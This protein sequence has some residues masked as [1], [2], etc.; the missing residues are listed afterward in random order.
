MAAHRD[1]L[2]NGAGKN[3]HI[4]QLRASLKPCKSQR[5][6]WHTGQFSGRANCRPRPV[7]HLMPAMTQPQET[8]M[9]EFFHLL[10]DAQPVYPVTIHFSVGGR[11][12][13]EQIIFSHP[14]SIPA[15]GEYVTVTFSDF[16]VKRRISGQVSH[17]LRDFYGANTVPNVKNGIIVQIW[18]QGVTPQP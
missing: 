10:Q 7:N 8:E 2:R 12:Y 14:V 11:D 13:S 18:L 17:V 4:S 3:G 6:R 15:S 16:G 9:P 1:H 5:P